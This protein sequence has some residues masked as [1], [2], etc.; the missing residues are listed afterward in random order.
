[1]KDIFHFAETPCNLRNNSTLKRRCIREVYFGTETISSLTP[2][3]C[4]LVPNASKINTSLELFKKEIKLWTID[5]CPCRLCKLYIGSEGFVK[6][7]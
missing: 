5:E 2:K 1:M 3:I 4:E 7:T 6:A